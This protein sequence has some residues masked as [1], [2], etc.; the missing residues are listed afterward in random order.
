MN[1]KNSMI[2]Y[3]SFCKFRKFFIKMQK[4]M[5]EFCDKKLFSEHLENLFPYRKCQFSNVKSIFGC[6]ISKYN[7]NSAF[8]GSTG[9]PIYQIYYTIVTLRQ[10]FH[11]FIG[12][13][14][15]C[16]RML[17]RDHC[18]SLILFQ[19]AY[20]TNAFNIPSFTTKNSLNKNIF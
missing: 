12:F 3:S 18:F 6:S 10:C 8:C 5:L 19:N 15:Y 2:K 13:F 4:I 11:S 20:Y 7:F 9:R 1:F 14:V 16:R 17:R